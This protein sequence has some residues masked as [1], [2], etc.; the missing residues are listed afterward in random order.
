VATLP[1][2]S[3]AAKRA[4]SAGPLVWFGLLSYSLYLVQQPFYALA[5][6]TIQHLAVLPLVV[7]LGFLS[8]RLVEAP[9]REWLNG[10]LG[11]RS[12]TARFESV[13]PA[14]PGQ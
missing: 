2:L 7:G 4:L 12:R 9:A 14:E 13:S 3:D 1:S 8:H 11:R 6:G 10:L 5:E